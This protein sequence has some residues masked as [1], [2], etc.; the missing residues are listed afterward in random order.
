MPDGTVVMLT[1]ATSFYNAKAE[2]F[3]FLREDIDD[4]VITLP[5][6]VEFKREMFIQKYKIKGGRILIEDKAVIKKANGGKS[7]DYFDATVIFNYKR[8]D[9]VL[10]GGFSL[11]YVDQLFRIQVKDTHGAY[12]RKYYKHLTAVQ[13]LIY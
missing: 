2:S 4:E 11:G 6:H 9:K 13:Q 3:W 8:R 7:P 5:E 1:T 12:S 10:N